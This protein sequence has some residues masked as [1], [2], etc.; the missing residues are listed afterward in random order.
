M[1]KY[2][3]AKPGQAVNLTN[4]ISKIQRRAGITVTGQLDD[5]TKKLFI[6]P[7]CGVAESED[8]DQ[9]YGG[10]RRKKRYNLQGT[11]WQKKVRM[12]V[13]KTLNSISVCCRVVKGRLRQVVRTFLT[14]YP[15]SNI[16]ALKQ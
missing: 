7:R 9:E 4:E 10:R 6:I 5:A 11:S 13:L 16:L 3:V 8:A 14:S 15:Q 2:S 1:L 12:I